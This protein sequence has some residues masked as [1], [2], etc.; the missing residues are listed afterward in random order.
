MDQNEEAPWLRRDFEYFTEFVLSVDYVID[1]LILLDS[2]KM[3]YDSEWQMHKERYIIG[4]IERGVDPLEIRPITLCL[5]PHREEFAVNDGISRLRAFKVKD[6]PNIRAWFIHG[7]DWGEDY[8]LIH[9]LELLERY[10]IRDDSDIFISPYSREL[11]C[12]ALELYESL[13]K[14]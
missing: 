10:G 6:I 7:I 3:I 12:K 13:I 8:S 9:A 11:L 1:H 5:H 14:I 2:V 4:E